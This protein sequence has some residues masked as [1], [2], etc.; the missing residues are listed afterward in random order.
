M[1]RRNDHTREE[2]REMALASAE[3]IIAQEGLAGLSTRKVATAIGYSVGALYTLF[4][5]LDDL[6]WQLNERTLSCLMAAIK[7]VD[8]TD[9]VACLQGCARIY[10]AFA[11]QYPERWRL[12]FEHRSNTDNP[13]PDQLSTRIGGLFEHIDGCLARLYP[14]IDRHERQLRSRILW[15]GIHGLTQ[16]EH[17][18]KL[19]LPDAMTA[20]DIR[21]HLIDSLLAGWDKESHHA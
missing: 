13:L 8:E 19:F 12:L 1:A 18:N 16:L 4:S 6:C 9:P 11:E 20:E 21:I 14:R 3:R 5:N 7:E 2:L 15:S 10:Q 17:S